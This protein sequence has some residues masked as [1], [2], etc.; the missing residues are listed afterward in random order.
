MKN[1]TAMGEFLAAAG[2]VF[3]ICTGYTNSTGSY[4]WL[5]K[6]PLLQCSRRLKIRYLF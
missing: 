6:T 4:L 3:C 1:W 5:D 2:V